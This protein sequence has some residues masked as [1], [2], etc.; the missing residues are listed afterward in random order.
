MEPLCSDHDWIHLS[1]TLRVAFE[2]ELAVVKN[3]DISD[4]IRKIPYLMSLLD[5]VASLRGQDGAFFSI[6]PPIQGDLQNTLYSNESAC[7]RAFHEYLKSLQT[8]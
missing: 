4:Q 2:Q 7:M 6:R 5:T 3:K 8:L 1:D